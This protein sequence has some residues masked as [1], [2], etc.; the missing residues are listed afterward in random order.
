MGSTIYCHLD[1]LKERIE[2]EI[3]IAS[4]EGYGK[5]KE[6]S[7]FSHSGSDGPIYGF[8]NGYNGDLRLSKQT[9]NPVDINQMTIE[10]WKDINYNFDSQNSVASFYGC[11]SASFA[12]KFLENTNVQ[13][14]AGNPGRAGGT[15]SVKGEFNSTLLNKFFNVDDSIYLR[16]EDSDTV[17]PMYLYKRATYELNYDNSK[18]LKEFNSYENPTVQ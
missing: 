18:D 9:G 13:S 4:K 14:A 5:T 3:S 15:Y 2:S 17:L 7:V 12:K 11:Q 6:L 10:G 8:S 1:K 16:A